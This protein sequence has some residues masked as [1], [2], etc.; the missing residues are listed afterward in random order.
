MRASLVPIPWRLPAALASA[1]LVLV[2]VPVSA[3]LAAGPQQVTMKAADFS[4]SPDTVT[5]TAG[6]PVQLTIVNEGK[7]DHDLKSAIPVS[8]LTYQEADNDP[9]EQKENSEQG[10]FDVDFAVGHT[11]QI[12]FTPT[13]AGSYEFFCDVPGHK[14]QGMKGMFVVQAA[15]GGPAALPNNGS[16]PVTPLLPW[17]A[18]IGAVLVATG[19]GIRRVRRSNADAA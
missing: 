6:Q 12:T 16:D 1:A 5:V 10:T 18:G 7:V 2:L 13:K 8:G 11:S 14:E 17:V 19:L 3:L 4:F 15:A 9:D